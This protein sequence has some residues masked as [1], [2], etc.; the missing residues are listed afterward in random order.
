MAERRSSFA[1]RAAFSAMPASAPTCGAISRA[2]AAIRSTRSH[3]VPSR[4]W[5]VT[6]FSPSAHSAMPAFATRRSLS[7]KNAASDRRAAS[8]RWLPFRIVA[9]SSGA[10]MLATV[11]KPSIRPVAGFRADRNFWC[12][13]IEVCSTSGGSDRNRSSITPISGTGHSTRPAISASSASSGTISH[14]RAKA[15]FAASCRI[16]ASRSSWSSMTRARRSFAA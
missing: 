10:S 8:T 3:W 2:S 16:A 9:P 1:T 7:Q 4:A 13:F 12:S 14:P 5:N 11:T 15:R 6:D